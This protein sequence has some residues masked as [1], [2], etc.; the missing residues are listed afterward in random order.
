MPNTCRKYDFLTIAAQLR[1]RSRFRLQD[2]CSSPRGDAPHRLPRRPAPC[3][4]QPGQHREEHRPPEPLLLYGRVRR[5]GPSS[6]R[7]GA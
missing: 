7:A 6:S 4:I 2:G 3:H 5:L 1:V